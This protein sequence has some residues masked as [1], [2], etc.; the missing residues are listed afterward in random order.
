MN[1]RT[2]LGV[3]S[4]KAMNAILAFG[5]S[6]VLARRLGP[7]GFGIYTTAFV[8]ACV[9]SVI[10]QFGLHNFVVRETAQG[11]AK[12]NW[13]RVLFVWHWA[14]KSVILICS[15]ILLL[16]FLIERLFFLKK[17]EIEVATFYISLLM[18]PLLSLSSLRVAALKGLRYVTISQIPEMVIKPG[19]VLILSLLLGTLIPATA[20][21]AMFIQVAAIGISFLA[22]IWLLSSRRPDQLKGKK[23][24][25]YNT[26][27]WWFSAL[28]MAFSAGMNQINGYADIL[29]LR[30]FSPPEDVGLY[31]VATQISMLS[32]FGLQVLASVSSPYFSRCFSQSDN[33]SLKKII[34]VSASLSLGFAVLNASIWYVYGDILLTYIFGAEY[35]SIGQALNVLLVGQMVNAFFGPIAIYLN[36]AN[37]ES[38]VARYMLIAAI[39]NVGLNFFLIPIF[40]SLGAAFS[41]IISLSV[42]NLGLWFVGINKLRLDISPFAWFRT[43]V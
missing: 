28:T 18:V 38:Y 2:V 8:L 40:G 7:E 32:V 31:R 6:V 10:G 16:S 9:L 21:H 5:I 42:W 26:Q 30:M 11:E 4:L 12:K 25:V 36:M 14:T 1:I 23:A 3:S 35:V 27:A 19:L 34:S 15:I 41:T 43:N 17:P 20:M 13:S 22:G 24:G 29:I 39:F 33:L 37:L